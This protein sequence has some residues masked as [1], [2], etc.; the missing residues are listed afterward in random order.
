MADEHYT[1]AAGLPSEEEK[2]DVGGDIE[3]GRI[4]DVSKNTDDGQRSSSLATTTA[5]STKATWTLRGLV[6]RHRVADMGIEKDDT[7]TKINTNAAPREN[8][9]RPPELNAMEQIEDVDDAAPLPYTFVKFDDGPKLKEASQINTNV[10]S[11][12]ITPSEH[13][14]MTLHPP[15][16]DA[17]EQIEEGE[18]AAPRP[19]N[20][21][22]F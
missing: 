16:Q 3:Q 18:D 14:F 9:P 12:K 1:P 7:N 19:F 17:M 10:H 5:P 22:E 2:N 21:A 4:I 6:Q 13:A 11:K 20:S 15:A 8:A